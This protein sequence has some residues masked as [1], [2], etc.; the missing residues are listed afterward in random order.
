MKGDRALGLGMGEMRSHPEL[1]DER[2][3]RRANA[4][5]EICFNYG[6]YT[7]P[8]TL[9][10]IVPSGLRVTISGLALSKY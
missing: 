1:T 8:S 5:L 9:T 7:T 4:I 2:R 10:A 3:M 6:G